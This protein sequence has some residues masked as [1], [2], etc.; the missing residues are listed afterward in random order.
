MLGIT[1]DLRLQ[2]GFFCFQTV[3]CGRGGSTGICRR[4]RGRFD[5]RCRVRGYWLGWCSR[6][7]GDRRRYGSGCRFRGRRCGYVG[8]L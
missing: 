3:G 2:G 6:L 4:R 7:R 5:Y 8:Y 1:G